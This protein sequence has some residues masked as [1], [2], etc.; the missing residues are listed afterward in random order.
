MKLSLRSGDFYN[1]PAMLFLRTTFMQHS[2]QLFSI[3]PA[4][5]SYA[6]N[7]EIAIAA[8][9]RQAFDGLSFGSLN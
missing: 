8:G 5:G 9:E 1:V 2:L 7:A 3:L 4:V 6:F